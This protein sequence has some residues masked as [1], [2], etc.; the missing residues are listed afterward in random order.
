VAAAEAEAAVVVEWEDKREEGL[1]FLLFLLFLL[2]F[3]EIF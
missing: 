3:G 2:V 1:V